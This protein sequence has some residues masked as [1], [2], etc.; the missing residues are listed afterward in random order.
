MTKAVYLELDRDVLN[1]IVS[2][3]G[4]SEPRK[5]VM[6]AIEEYVQPASP[7]ISIKYFSPAGGIF[8]PEEAARFNAMA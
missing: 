3:A 1:Q 7:E 2:R 8:S 6:R 5:A 4:I